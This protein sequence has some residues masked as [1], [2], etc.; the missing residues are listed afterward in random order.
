MTVLRPFSKT[1]AVFAT[2][3]LSWISLSLNMYERGLTPSPSLI[4]E[5]DLINEDLETLSFVLFEQLSETPGQ[6]E[7]SVLSISHLE[8]FPDCKSNLW[9][10]V[11]GEYR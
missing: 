5:T 6:F 7:G 10:L 1:D 8:I 9:G 4:C 2:P 3:T 11:F